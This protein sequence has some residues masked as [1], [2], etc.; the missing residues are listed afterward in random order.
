MHHEAVKELT[1][2]KDYIRYCVS[3]FLDASVCFGHGIESP[4]EEAIELVLGALKLPRDFDPFFFDSTLTSSERQAIIDMLQ[5]RVVKRIPLAY[6]T[7]EAIFA[8]Y[9][10]Y[11]DDRVLV[12]RSPIAEL[13]DAGFQPWFC[14]REPTRILDLCT[15]SGCIAI[16]C[17]YAFPEAQV[18]AV[19]ISADAIEVAK[20]NIEKHGAE[21]LVHPIQSDLFKGVA[22][23]KYDIIVSNPP[24]VDKR[25]MGALPQEFRHEP[26]LGLAA[27]EDGL[28][29][30]HQILA[31]A[32]EY[33]ADDGILIVE[34]GNSQDALMETY[35]RIPFYWLEFAH[36]GHGVFMLTAQQ[37]QE[38]F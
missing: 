5:K 6:L 8:G 4:T 10:F 34:V 11:V 17:A 22:G 28:D 1:T 26:E 36:G 30:V 16:A 14:D 15:G 9:S 33:L 3:R 27:G 21:A 35:P 2:I 38:F 18:D 20:I 37:L 25:D 19:D 32:K 24:Y 29:I 7:N 12:P 13:I 23:E 31:E